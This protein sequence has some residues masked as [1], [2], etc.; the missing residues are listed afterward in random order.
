VGLRAGLEGLARQGAIARRQGT[1]RE[2]EAP[3]F[4]QDAERRAGEAV[5]GRR[6]P[7]LH[8]RGAEAVLP[9]QV[10][11]I[12]VGHIPVWVL[13]GEESAAAPAAGPTRNLSL[14]PVEDIPDMDSL[15]D[16]PVARPLAPA[17]P[18]AMA[19]HR[20]VAAAPGRTRLDESPQLASPDALDALEE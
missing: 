20:A 9:F 10:D 2:I 15:L 5:V 13:T 16:H 19:G 18:A 11:G 14:H 6:D 8:E 1:C 17:Q 7:A 4:S 12:V 3:F